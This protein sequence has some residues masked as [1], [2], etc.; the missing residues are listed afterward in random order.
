M[1]RRPTAVT[2]A[3]ISR[4]LAELRAGEI[5]KAKVAGNQPSL[6]SSSKG[7]FQP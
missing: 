7:P 1:G 3:M 2:Q 4:A 6:A 5:R